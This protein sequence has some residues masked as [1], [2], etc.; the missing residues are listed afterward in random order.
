MVSSEFYLVKS[1]GESLLDVWRRTFAPEATGTA[2]ASGHFV[3]E[4]N[5][6]ATLAA[7]QGFLQ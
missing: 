5:A 6:P 7:L 1:A 4:E 3:A 2:I